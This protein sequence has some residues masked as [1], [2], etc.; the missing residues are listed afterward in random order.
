MP[1][2]VSTLAAAAG[3]AGVMGLAGAP[4]AVAHTPA[5]PTVQA[6]P[7]ALAPQAAHDSARSPGGG[8]SHGAGASGRQLPGVVTAV[9]AVQAA[10]D[11]YVRVEV[12]W[13][14]PATARPRDTF[15]V[16]LPRELEPVDGASFAVRDGHGAPVATARVTGH[17]VEFT[18]TDEI[19]GRTGVTGST[20][21]T[22]RLVDRSRQRASVRL[23]FGAPGATFDASLDVADETPRDRSATATKDQRWV[24]AARSR[25]PREA[26]AWTIAAPRLTPQTA[27]APVTFVEEPGPGQAIDCPAARL[28]WATRNITAPDDAGPV[29]ATRQS[30]SCTPQRLVAVVQSTRA[31][32]G[33]IPYLAGT[34]TR[35][36]ATHATDATDPTDATGTTG[37]PLERYANNGTVTIGTDTSYTV[38]HV[39]DAP[40]GGSARSASLPTAAAVA[41]VVAVSGSRPGSWQ[42]PLGPLPTEEAVQ[43][44]PLAGASA[45]LTLT[46]SAVLLLARRRRDA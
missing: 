40:L 32:A 42:P 46:G 18:F 12:T 21:I 7:A 1:L 15:T 19:A 3:I 2:S 36:D 31:D 10:A 39:L 30:T 43:P 5:A 37:T 25:G 20:W 14:A 13:A 33:R 38:H 35:T 45:A 26:I 27:G 17:L 8:G 24:R 6:A 23:A 11:G 41:G 9:D 28:R 44:W 29:V 16:S 4:A 34:S 22:A